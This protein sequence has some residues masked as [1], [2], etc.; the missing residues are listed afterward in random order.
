MGDKVY[1]DIEDGV[2]E[3]KDPSITQTVL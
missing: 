2:E 3:S 1:L